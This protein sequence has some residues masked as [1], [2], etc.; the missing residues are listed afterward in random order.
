VTQSSNESRSCKKN[1]RLDR[2][3]GKWKDLRFLLVLPGE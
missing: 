1:R 3:E 2:S